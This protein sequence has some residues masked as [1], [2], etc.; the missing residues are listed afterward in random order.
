V[1][2]LLTAGMG[3]LGLGLLLWAA[4]GPRRLYP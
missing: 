4:I 1:L 3:A 2:P